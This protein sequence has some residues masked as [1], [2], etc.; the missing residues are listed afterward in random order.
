MTRARTVSAPAVFALMLALAGRDECWLT[1]REWHAWQRRAR[2]LAE[3]WNRYLT[4]EPGRGYSRPR[5]RTIY[6]A[7]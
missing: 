2:E 4:R 5:L 7:R 1:D 3:Q 6:L